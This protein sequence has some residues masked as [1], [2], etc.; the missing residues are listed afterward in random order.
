MLFIK[1]HQMVSFNFFIIHS[2]FESHF[3][4][5]RLQKIKA[6]CDTYSL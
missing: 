3:L 4:V 2:E 5:L 6:W 1:I